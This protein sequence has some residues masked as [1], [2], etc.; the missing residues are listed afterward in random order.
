MQEIVIMFKGLAGAKSRLN[1]TL[2]DARHRQLVLEMLD[3][4]VTTARQAIEGEVTLL[5]GSRLM[6]GFCR[7][8][9]IN[10]LCLPSDTGADLNAVL[11]A[12]AAPLGPRLILP[13]DL[14]HITVPDICQLFTL[15]AATQRPLIVPCHK[16]SGTNAL[17]YGP[18]DRGVFAFGGNSFAAHMQTW[19]GRASSAL[20]VENSNIAIDIDCR[21]DLALW[22]S[23]I[24]SG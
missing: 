19:S 9:N 24:R 10:L 23:H 2:S 11:N 13:S 7:Q 1:P 4:V 3:H 6:E 12:L 16:K 21:E 18:R 17:L 20:R 22:S 15:Y 8:A 5:C 14:P